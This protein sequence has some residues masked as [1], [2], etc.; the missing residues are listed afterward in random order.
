MEFDAN[1]ARVTDRW[2]RYIGAMGIEAVRLQS[3]A[4]VLLI[5]MGALGLEIAKNIVLSGI[6]KL[7]LSDWKS[8][9]KAELLG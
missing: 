6:Q 9:E 1:D 5:G 2:S 4:K 3:K 7:I 8:L